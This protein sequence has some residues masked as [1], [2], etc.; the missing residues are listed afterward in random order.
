MLRG[1]VNSNICSGR[2]CIRKSY[3][4]AIVTQEHDEDT[5][6]LCKRGQLATRHREIFFRE[7]TKKGYVFCRVVVPIQC[8]SECGF[9]SFTPV[10]DR[11]VEAAVRREYEKLT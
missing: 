6:V 10:A 7:Q 9:E 2:V 11:I 1:S 5:C 8:C 3:E 4:E